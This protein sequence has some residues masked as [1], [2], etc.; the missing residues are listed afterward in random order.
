M[1]WRRTNWTT[2]V[3]VALCLSRAIA[4]ANAG[5]ILSLSVYVESQSSPEMPFGARAK[6]YPGPAPLAEIVLGELSARH[7]K[8]PVGK[9][10]EHGS[11]EIG[12]P[13]CDVE[14]GRTTIVRD[15]KL[16]VAG[17]LP[18]ICIWRC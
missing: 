5:Q 6:I 18:K 17:R 14:S 15:R 8:D 1:C 11:A 16:L 3:Y 12:E 7:M 13:A 10:L 9:A 2:A 4:N